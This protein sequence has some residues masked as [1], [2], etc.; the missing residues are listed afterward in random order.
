MIKY[1]KKMT[2]ITAQCRIDLDLPEKEIRERDKERKEILKIK[3]HKKY[4]TY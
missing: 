1:C 3:N 4:M 2:L